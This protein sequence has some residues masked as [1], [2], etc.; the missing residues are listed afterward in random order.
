MT[1]CYTE[2]PHNFGAIE[3]YVI[4]DKVQMIQE[5]LSCE[6]CFL[7]DT[8]SFRKHGQLS[9]PEYLFDFIRQYHSSVIIIRCVLMELASHSGTLDQEY[10]NYISKMHQAGIKVFIVYEEDLFDVL[11]ACFT[12]I[13]SINRLLALA[14]I[15]TKTAT[16]TIQ[17]VLSEDKT[18]KTEL[19]K[20]KNSDNSLYSRFFKAVRQNKES[21]DHLGEELL[22]LCVHLLANIPEAH[23]YKYIVLTEDKG[24][25]R[26]L[27]KAA[28]NVLEYLNVRVFSAM[29]TAKL[30]FRMYEEGIITEQCQVQEI[31]AT[32][33]TGDMIGILGCEEYDLEPKEKVMSCEELA[34][35][36]VGEKRIYVNY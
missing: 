7:Y 31:L 23:S 29:T 11:S 20:K 12:T 19:F 35:K 21:G 5:F 32:G 18:L 36:I 26:L 10:I 34:E 25:I 22:T 2:T 17:S 33:I 16:G 3:P 27:K 6:K 15:N 14:V 24:A 13:A 28:K 30:T 4:T 9:H 1:G 8:C